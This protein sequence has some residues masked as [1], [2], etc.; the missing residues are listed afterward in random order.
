MPDYAGRIARAQAVLREAGIGGAVV[1]P[2][3]QMRY[4]T[5]WAEPGHERLIALF[6]PAIGEPAFVV[7]E[8]NAEQARTNAAGIADVRGWSDTSGWHALAAKTV[9]D[10]GIGGLVAV[11]DEL[12]SAHLLALQ[13][14]EPSTH[15]QVLSPI[16]TRLREIKGADELD[17]M[18]RSA[19]VADAA[20]EAV[21]PSLRPGVT[22]VA[23]RAELG[24]YF[25]ERGARSWFGLVCFGPNSALP[26]HS[27]GAT[28][29]S[30]GDVVILDLG[31]VLDDYSSDITRTV[32]FGEPGPGARQV[33]E[34]VLRAHRAAQAAAK[35]GAACQ[36]VDRAA[37]AV[38]A[39]AGY[40]DYFI[41]RTGHGIGVSCHEPPY[42]VEGS[43][44][45]LEPGMCFSDEPGIYLPGRY[46]VR[47]E[48]ILA[49]TEAG[50]ESLNAAPPDHLVVLG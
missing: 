2:S 42:I 10:L 37:R 11:D 29:L 20:Y 45:L 22:E 50:A 31:C 27:S 38:I 48:N 16:M 6:L 35:P 47:I 23:I 40:G 13:A 14:N 5:G 30:R 34:I 33:Y 7:P 26:H 19:A 12:L 9:S 4:L 28:T 49:V 8:M 41:H 44:R 1:A 36:D 43:T 3:D 32:A 46:G 24:R 21:L 25:E 39:E 17:A 15:W 18:R